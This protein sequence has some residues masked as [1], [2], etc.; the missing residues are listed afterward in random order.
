M[1]LAGFGVAAVLAVALLS[2]A[3]L[4]V[5]LD[6][7]GQVVGSHEPF[8]A[9]GTGE[10]LLSGVCPEVSLEF[11]RAREAFSAEQ[12]VADEGPLTGVPPQVGLQVGGFSVDFPTPG[13]V[14]AVN[15]PLA[16]VSSGGT[17]PLGLL[18]VWAVARGPARVASRRALRCG[19]G[20]RRRGGGG[21]EVEGPRV[22]SRQHRFVGIL[23]QV[24]ASAEQLI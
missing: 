14:A 2:V 3:V 16:K 9:D 1:G 21:R 6:M 24:L 20:G 22:R 11:V 19:Q 17:E 4:A 7:F 10:P 23:K 15:V 8:V 5:G 13:Y 18:A 12:P